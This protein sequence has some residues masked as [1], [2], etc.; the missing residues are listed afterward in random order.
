[1]GLGDKERLI[2]E[3]LLEG[4]S[5]ADPARAVEAAVKVVGGAARIMGSLELLLRGEIHVVGFGKASRGMVRGLLRVLGDM[6]AGGVVIH[7]GDEG[8]EGPVQVLRGD[9]PI[10]GE[11]TLR[12]SEKLLGYIENEVSP[13]DIVFVLISGGG[14]ALFEQPRPGLSLDDIARVS[15]MLMESGADIVELNTVRKHLSMVKGGWLAKRIRSRVTVSLIISD[16]VRDPVEFIASGP[17]APDPTTFSDALRVMKRRRVWDKAPESVKRI[18]EMGVKGL[19][20]ETPKPGDP[21]FE[22]TFNY[23]VASNAISLSAI[24]NFLSSRGY[25]VLVLTPY[26]EG[27]ARE[28]GKALAGIAY[29]AAKL[30][31]PLEPP[32]AIIAGGETTVTVRGSG[33]GGRNQE[34]CLS[35]AIGIRGVEGVYAGCMGSDGID[36]VSPAAGALVSYKTVDEA[37]SMGLDPGEY[38]ENNDS[39]TFFK[40]LGRTIETGLTGTNVNDFVVLLIDKRSHG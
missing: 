26:M 36:G 4:V 7:P 16:V 2:L 12:S 40:K 1:M 10:P 8:K 28:I 13:G 14:S 18:I 38:L 23:I 15:R 33:I 27:E 11:N 25:N 31:I 20:E 29:S 17:T 19:I 24:K 9:H 6:V 39:Y 30:G 3:A 22:R 32:C 21:V 35:I 34:L 5:A 37:V